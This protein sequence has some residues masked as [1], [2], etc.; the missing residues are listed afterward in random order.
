[1]GRS[2]LFLTYIPRQPL[3]DFVQ[4]F[5]YSEGYRPKHAKEHHLPTGTLELVINLRE[6]ALRV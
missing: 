4:L 1:M 6:D 3:A 2:P 5:W